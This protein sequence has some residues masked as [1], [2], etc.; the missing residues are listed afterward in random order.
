MNDLPK[1]A[2]P[3]FLPRRLRR[4]LTYRR[5]VNKLILAREDA[6]WPV[7]GHKIGQF[8]AEAR[9]TAEQIMRAH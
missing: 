4:W 2:G 9:Q 5:E 1:P 7:S 8:T 6:G 3:R